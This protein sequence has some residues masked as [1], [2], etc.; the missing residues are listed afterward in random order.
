M[1]KL[2]AEELH[3]MGVQGGPEIESNVHQ[4]IMLTDLAGTRDR[5]D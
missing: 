2:K 3:F 5:D 1:I 4:Q